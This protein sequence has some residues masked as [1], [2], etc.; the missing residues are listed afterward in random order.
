MGS[1]YIKPLDSLRAFAA[2]SVVIF[3]YNYFFFKSM[4]QTGLVHFY[5]SVL[6]FGWLGVDLFF[7][8]SGFLITRLLLQQKNSEKYFKN[9][10]IR[11][12]LRIF[13]LYYGVLVLYFVLPLLL[14]RGSPASHEVSANQI[15]LW[16]YLSNFPH[17]LPE[18]GDLGHFWSLAVEEHFYL[19]WPLIVYTSSP[20]RIQTICIS[21]IAAVFALRFGMHGFG[22]DMNYLGK[23][24]FCRIDTILFGAWLAVWSLENSSS[25]IVHRCNGVLRYGVPVAL[26][27]I[28]LLAFTDLRYTAIKDILTLTMYPVYSAVFTA[29][30]GF[31]SFADL[32]TGIWNFLNSRQLQY[33]GKISYGIYIFHL[34]CQRLASVL[35]MKLFPALPMYYEF[36]LVQ[37][38][39]V[40]FQIAITIAV[41]A[42]S[43]H[44]FESV[45]LKMKDRF[46]SRGGAE[47]FPHRQAS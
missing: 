37:V 6:D 39:W 41:S 3:H 25:A 36:F 47:N 2:L 11:R 23:N 12:A 10:Y 32:K 20:R 24:S 46:T 8:L 31:V 28:A 7:V 38:C 17:P 21:T 45:F 30:I 33:L 18:L 27:N 29:L 1:T 43:W 14:G 15:W 13:P 42:L 34:P 19:F 35:Q 5:Y 16:T 4:P 26:A 44:T 22:F 9:F 40:A